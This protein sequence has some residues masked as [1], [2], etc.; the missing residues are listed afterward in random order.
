MQNRPRTGRALIFLIAGLAVVAVP[1]TAAAPA[2]EP[3][4]ARTLASAGVGVSA[5]VTGLRSSRGQ[6][7]ACLTANA[8]AFPRC[9]NDPQARGRTIPA[10]GPLRIEFG[11]VPAGNYAIALIHD[12]NANGRLDK[13]LMLPNEGFGFSRNA[14][15]KF[16]PPRFARAAFA[17]NTH[18]PHQTIRMRYIF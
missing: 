1:G 18:T 6:V 8:K 15:V 4:P 17:V 10:S 9:E 5:T 14:P 11:E 7:I 16:G 13:R 3:A 2:P 12:E